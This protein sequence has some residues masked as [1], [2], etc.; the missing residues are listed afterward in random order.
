MESVRTLYVLLVGVWLASG[1]GMHAYF[2]RAAEGPVEIEEKR[3]L[4]LRQFENDDRVARQ[5]RETHWR[6]GTAIGGAYTPWVAA[7]A[8]LAVPVLRSY[9][10]KAEKS[11]DA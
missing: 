7:G 11:F 1:L 3:D 2:S 10:K 6:S 5:I 4:Y 9:F 8:L